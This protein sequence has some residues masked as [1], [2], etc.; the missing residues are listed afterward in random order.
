MSS[1]LANGHLSIDWRTYERHP[2]S[3]EYTDLEGPAWERF[4]GGVRDRGIINGRKIILFEGKIL[5]GWQLYRACL[6]TDTEPEFQEKPDDIEAEE[7]VRTVND[8][9]R[10]ETQEVAMR[11]ASARRERVA[12]LR[13][14]G[15]SLPSIAETVG[16][17][18]GQVQR[19]IA[20]VQTL[21][22]DKVAPKGGSVTGKDGKK[23]KRSTV[24]RPRKASATK[25]ESTPDGKPSTNGKPD[26]STTDDLGTE[27]P[28][29]L[30]PVFGKVPEFKGIVSQLNA[31]NRKLVE[32]SE[33]PAGACMR[34][35]AAQIDLK[36]LKET[37]KF[38]TP[39]CVCPVC[40]GCAK[41]R[42]TNCPCKQR[43]WLIE[44]AYKNL[45][46]EFRQ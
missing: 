4:L 10:H 11:R 14:Q 38:D 19:D 31:I 6:E 25:P 46:A 33:T 40:K 28:P 42:K 5:D 7:Y 9:R 29:G 15:N 26:E 17:S 21:S 43:G 18:V 23:R 36:N 34:L 39:Y 35:Q 8:D 22:G 45:P 1:T 3:A 16:V 27:I 12:E 30:A 44:G 13:K 41:T 24:G 2:L 20:T 32:L 37:V